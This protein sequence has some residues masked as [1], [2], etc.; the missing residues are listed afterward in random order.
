MKSTILQQTLKLILPTLVNILLT[1]FPERMIKDYLDDLIDV[2]ED[3]IASSANELD[4]F[5]LPILQM[6]RDLFDIPDND[7]PQEPS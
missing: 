3:R 4:D 5:A 2:I 1:S 6:L 7:D